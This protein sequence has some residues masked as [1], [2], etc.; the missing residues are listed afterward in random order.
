VL[1]LSMDV[2]QL[3]AQLLHLLQRA[4]ATVQI[5]ARPAAAFQHATQQ[6]QAPFVGQIVGF[7]PGDRSRQIVEREFST[8]LGARTALADHAGIAALS[9]Y[10]CER[11]DQ[12]RLA[13]T[14][15]AGE[16]GEAGFELEIEPIDDDEIA[17]GKRAQHER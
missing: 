8:D 1:V 3:L 14:G 12:N 16:D 15:F 17:D 6:A 13:G 7:E 9:Q 4:R 10:Q 11:V 2:D 5:R